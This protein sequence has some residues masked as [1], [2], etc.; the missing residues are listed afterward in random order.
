MA[1]YTI[2]SS[3]FILG[4]A[5]VMGF[6]LTSYEAFIDTSGAAECGVDKPPCL[7][8]NK[9]INGWCASSTPPV[10]PRLTGLPVLP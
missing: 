8:P 10:L 5:L 1:V 7:G 2:L 4:F 9:C 6:V 3:L